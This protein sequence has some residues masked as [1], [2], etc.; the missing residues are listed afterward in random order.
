MNK[1]LIAYDIT[2]LQKEIS[3]GDEEDFSNIRCQRC[4]CV[5]VIK[6]GYWH[7]TA[8]C[9]ICNNQNSEFYSNE[10]E[11]KKTSEYINTL[12]NDLYYYNNLL[13]VITDKN[14]VRERNKNIIIP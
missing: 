12:I 7:N 11:I 2:G 10:E 13:K 4:N 9:P 8:V 14:K 5:L 3:I 1:K 6:S